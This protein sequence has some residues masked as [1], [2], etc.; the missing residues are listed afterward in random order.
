M[1][2]M[3]KR[4][5]EHDIELIIDNNIV[6]NDETTLFVCSGMQQLKSK[7]LDPDQT[8]IGTLQSC[9]R[10]NDIDLIGDGSHLSYFQMLGNFSFGRNDYHESVEMWH[11]IVNDLGIEIDHITIHPSKQQHRKM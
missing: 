4:F 8:K 3:R 7:F 11:Q 10:T 1:D 9:V 5:G 2:V 6:P